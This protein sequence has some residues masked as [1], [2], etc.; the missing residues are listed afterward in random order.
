VSGQPAPRPA[1]APPAPAAAPPAPAPAVERDQRPLDLGIIRRLFG[2]MRPHARLRNLL[3][4]LVFVRAIQLPMVTWATAR[5]ISGPIA[6]RDVGGTAL[7][8]LGFLLLS[9][10][11]EGCFVFRMRFALRLGE[12]VVYDL[13]NA[14]YAQLMRMPMSYFS[15]T[16]VGRLIGRVT[17]DL[18]VVR[19]GVQDVAFVSTVSAGNLVVSAVLMLYY[20]WRLFAVVM[21]MA[22]GLYALMH[23]FR[24]KLSQ[25]YRAQQESF[26]RVTATLAES[27]SGIREIQAFAR[28]GVSAARFGD[29]IAFHSNNNMNAARQSAVFQPLLELNG[30]IFLAV[31]VVA[32]GYRALGHHIPVATLIQFLFLSN[33]FFGS[34]PNLGTQ[35]N[36]A[37]TAMAGAERVFALLDRRPDWQDAPDAAPLPPAPEPPLAG[38]IELRDVG[39]EYQ[40]G[41]PVLSGVSLTV[42][43][44]QTVA[45]VGPTGSGKSTVFNLVAKLYLPTS[46]AVLIEGHDLA[47]VTGLSLHQRIACVTQENFLFS[48]TVLDNVRVGRPDASDDDVRAAARALDVLDLVEALP[49]GFATVVSEKG[50][51][52]SVGQRQ[53]ICFLRAMLADPRILLLDEATS[54]VDTLTERRLQAA[55]LRLLAGRT[56][57][58]IAHRL[59]TIRHADQ[60]LVLDGGRVVERG[61]HAELV[62]ASG[63]YAQ[64]HRRLAAA[65][66]PAPAN[67]DDARA[68][69]Q[70]ESA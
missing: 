32:G 7:G 17:S 40:R 13:R 18:E 28:Q 59:G 19:T 39:F 16:P 31:L 37:L 2:Y 57:L 65:S 66:A 38:R 45:L 23:H 11:T 69:D 34:I 21:V 52:L 8:V 58:V 36:Q 67:D 54:A 25:A 43:A 50:A 12:L 64:M 70:R 10:F 48:G 42:E 15:R 68:G 60:V 55:L 33:A 51:G 61:T 24:A 63:L 53:V 27:V 56:C 35:Y 1:A 26:S 5:V 62:A 4:G 3:F 47:R 6:R 29:L 22:P 30:Q 14:I 41:R 49:G 9:A 44:G 46:G 20:D